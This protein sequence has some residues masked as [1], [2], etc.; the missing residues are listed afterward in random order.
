MRRWPR[1]RESR[2]T[3]RTAAARTAG[4]GA[5]TIGGR[6]PTR[7]VLAVVCV[8]GCLAVAAVA[9]AGSPI[10]YTAYVA[11]LGS[12][13]LTPINTATNAASS[14]STVNDPSAVAITPD[15]KDGIGGELDGGHRNAHHALDDDGRHP[16]NVGNQP[17]AI[18]ITP[19]GTKAYVANYNGNGAG[20]V[21]AITLSND[22]TST[23]TVGQGPYAIA[24]TPDGTKAFV[25]NHHDGTVTP[26]TIASNTA[27]APITVG[28]G[29]A[30]P[31][32]IAIT[33]DGTTAYV[34]N[35]ARQHRRS[36]HHRDEHR[37]HGN[38]RHSHS[39]WRSRSLLT[40]RRHTSPRTATQATWCQ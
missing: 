16:I 37:R 26:I 30:Q 13:S 5:E 15:G 23:I 35:N 11:N 6:R 3:G 28:P 21:T 2:G 27:G 34:A 24:I 4:V 18:A 20:T 19:D 17:A 22:A 40:A 32:A 12:G 36:D 8:G 31:V 29:G 7:L 9:T 38:H 10:A 39:D 33:P 25:A 14:P 1:R